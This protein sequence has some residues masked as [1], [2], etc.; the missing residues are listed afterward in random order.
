MMGTLGLRQC[1]GPGACDTL[2]GLYGKRF[3]KARRAYDNNNYIYIINDYIYTQLMIIY[4][5]NE[6]MY[7]YHYIYIYIRNGARPHSAKAS[8]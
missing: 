4:I 8:G 7:A 1:L 3:A 2:L 5:N 6:F